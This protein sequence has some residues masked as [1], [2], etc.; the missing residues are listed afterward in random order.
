M[1][2][3]PP[4]VISGERHRE[5]GRPQPAGRR[6]GGRRRA[7]GL[8]P[9]VSLWIGIGVLAAG[10]V[11]GEV[12]TFESLL[13][14]MADRTAVTRWPEPAY[15]QLQASSYDRRSRTPDDPA[16]WFANS[17]RGHAIR[18][19]TNQGRQEWVLMEH[20]GPGVLT[21]LWTP[22]FYWDFNNRRG[23]NLRIYLDGERQPELEA[24]FIAL[25]RG[26][27]PVK[28]P[29]AQPTTRAGD[30]YLPISFG[31]SCKI[32]TDDR[33]FYYIINYR[34]YSAGTEVE[35]FRMEMLET[36]RSLMAQVAAELTAPT[37]FTAGEEQGFDAGIAAGQTRSVSL[38]AGPAA[39][40][41][42][43]LRLEAE[44]LAQALRSTVL[45][46][47]F[48]G[49]R[50]VWCPV[51][52][53]FS[54]IN[55]LDPFKTWTREVRPDGTLI[56]RWIMPYRD[57]AE[58][59]LLNLASRPVQA[60]LRV[61]VGEWD[62]G[63]DSLRFH[64]TWRTAGP[65]PPRPV[66]DMNFVE[67]H[68][69]GVH[70]GDTLVVLN[71]H[72]SWW[73]EGDEKIYVDGD[74]DRRFP[75]HFGTGTEDYYGWA[76]GEVPTR[77]DEYSSPFSANVRVGGQTRDWPAGKEPYTHG[78]NICTRVRSLDA[79]PFQQRFRFDLEAFNMIDTPDAWLQYALVA[80][81][82]AAPGATHN[83]PPLPEEAAAPV[84]QTEDVAAAARKLSWM[85]DLSADPSP[86]LVA[87]DT[88][89][90]SA[91][92]RGTG[93]VE[94]EWRRN[95]EVFQRNSAPAGSFASVRI[96][97]VKE[98]DAGEYQV[99]ARDET[100]TIESSPVAVRVLPPE[101]PRPG[102]RLRFRL[103]EDDPGAAPGQV[104]RE[105]TVDTSGRWRLTPQG[106]P[107]YS[108]RQAVTAQAHSLEFQGN[109]YY[110]GAGP[111]W[112]SLFASF[113]WN[114]FSLA[115]DVFIT[116]P[117]EAGYSFPV[118]I[119]GDSTGLAVF[120]EKGHWRVLHHGVGYSQPGPEV[121]YNT[122]THIELRRMNFG[123]GVESRLFIDGRDTGVA[124]TLPMR[125]P[126]GR[127]LIGAN[128]HHGAPEG[129]FH[130]LVDNVTLFTYAEDGP[131][132][133][134][135]P[136]SARPAVPEEAGSPALVG[137]REVVEFESLGEV[138]LSL[139][140]EGETQFIGGS[141]PPFRWSHDAQF[142]GKATAPGQTARFR[143]RGV[144]GPRRL[145]LR[146]SR[147]HD[148]G[149]LEVLVN[150]RPVVRDWDAYAPRPQPAEPVD[151]GV[152]S[153]R[154]G[155]I[156]LTV[157]VTGR[158]PRSSGHYFGLDALVMEEV[159]TGGELAEQ[160]RFLESGIFD[161]ITSSTWPRLA[162]VVREPGGASA[163][164]LQWNPG[165]SGRAV[166]LDFGELGLD[167]D[168]LHAIWSQRD[169]RFL[170]FARQHWT[171][172]VLPARGSLYLRL[173]PV[174]GVGD[175]P[176]LIGSTL[177]PHCG[178]REVRLSRPRPDLLEVELGS[179][180]AREGDFFVF[181]RRPLLRG[182]A[183]GCRLE[184]VDQIAEQ[185]WRIRVVDRDLKRPQVVRLGMVVP[186]LQRRSFW[187]VV[188][189]VTSAGLLGGWWVRQRQQARLAMARLEQRH[190]IEQERARIARDLHDDLG[191]RLTE[192][193][194]MSDPENP[195]FADWT[196]GRA[197]LQ[198]IAAR[199][200]SLL[201]SF[202]E[203]V[204][205]VNPR[206]DNLPRLV[207]HLCSMSEELCDTAGLRCW[208]E[209]P[210]VAPPWPLPVEV[211]HGLAMAVRESL[212]N[213]IRHAGASQ[214]W[215]RITIHQRR[216]AITVEDDGCGFDPAAAR[217]LGRGLANIRQRL[218]EL[219]GSVT[220]A[221]QPGMGT[222]ITLTL[223]LASSTSLTTDGSETPRGPDTAGS[224]GAPRVTK[225]PG[226]RESRRSRRC[227]PAGPN[228][229]SW[230]PK[231]A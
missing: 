197:Q 150:G 223:A 177:D 145:W 143:V 184:A 2:T 52:D 183:E 116:A 92:A 94:Y 6:G 57:R 122:W 40:R 72:W 95:G 215:L 157:R 179:T 22:F 185:V 14:E 23:P 32:T 60:R 112:E 46:M 170:G 198:R 71:P 36:H 12:V 132:V 53:F 153:P 181:S 142:L 27:G 147:S 209:V 114:R 176:V 24:N 123:Q 25:V 107:K 118:S 159:G 127:L 56:C 4:S 35:T 128:I 77:R 81:F 130:G 20:E 137:R 216:L 144:A 64:T 187:W 65:F 8:L 113:D 214:V 229:A 231:S 75:S 45:E 73:G 168:R 88:L 100:G 227:G 54:N 33:P 111:S 167:P 42:L 226:R 129:W 31:R 203:I 160:R 99:L 189:A 34:A 69:R 174:D 201:E 67:V 124:A 5:S 151:L 210:P 106:T 30:L 10:G 208:H 205:M 29:F 158:N 126:V 230:R 98:T 172:P 103:G 90:L 86:V 49:E 7:W 152:Q 13:R 218:A 212:C 121:A 110:E 70:V 228:G 173:T 84:P 80:H 59:R 133:T 222:R 178:I 125:A 154:D 134:V 169:R 102:L 85:D 21:R 182:E 166:T 175:R 89:V 195:A 15:R 109:G 96:D 47:H 38:P 44:D 37:N 188:G 117:G 78:Y 104:S 66:R 39:V 51:G 115:F 63:A 11:A 161:Q 140:M 165:G 50:T 55:G 101:S 139:G 48:D 196:H 138:E 83:R 68:G 163:L 119:G 194:L 87:G 79:I 120:E 1:S 146:A 97:A 224:G 155:A 19:E 141:L 221:S 74:F 213:V 135:L 149:I 136:R 148:Y 200:R 191:A 58:L 199:A 43:E 62:W 16:G 82:Y 162:G 190:A 105:A 131:R 207:D 9:A 202:N 93:V 171:T 164:V 217:P 28:P 41:H 26:Q 206:N 204:W 156:E 186:L 17:D 211:R 220:I 76:G 180:G 18:T 61:V 192:I 91:R 3:V 193:A 219:G 225:A 108:A